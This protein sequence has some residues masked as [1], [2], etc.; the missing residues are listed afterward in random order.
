MVSGASCRSHQSANQLSSAVDYAEGTRTASSTTSAPM[1]LRNFSRAASMACSSVGLVPVAIVH[2]SQSPTPC[3]FKRTLWSLGFFPLPRC[4]LTH[5]RGQSGPAFCF[6]PSKAPA[7]YVCGMRA[8]VAESQGVLGDQLCHAGVR[9][10][11][12]GS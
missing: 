2:D 7:H 8:N 1:F 4:L 10:E 3:N 9:Q 12:W 11:A 5:N 6:P